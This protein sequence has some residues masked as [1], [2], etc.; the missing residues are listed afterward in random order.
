L[1]ILRKRKIDGQ[2]FLDMSK[3]D[4]MQAGLEMGP[5]M[6]LAKEVQALKDK[7]KRAFST[8]RSLKAVL[9]KYGIDSNG[10]DT[11]PL[12]SLQTYEIQDSNK[13]FEHCGEYFVQDET[14]RVF[15]CGYLESMPVVFRKGRVKLGSFD[16]TRVYCKFGFKNATGSKL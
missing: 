15:G 4:F 13:H 5:A 7:P 6:K 16:L 11:I 14:L 1:G 3:D 12:F 9:A 8:Y 10:T 2:V